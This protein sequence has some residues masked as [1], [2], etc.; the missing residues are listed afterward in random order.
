MK[1]LGST[2]LWAALAAVMAVGS[3]TFAVDEPIKDA[4]Q[5]SKTAYLGLGVAPMHPALTRQLPDVIG[6]GQGVLVAE[7]TKGSISS[8]TT[9]ETSLSST[10]CSRAMCPIEVIVEAPI[11]RTRSAIGSVMAKI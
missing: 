9:Y 8:G 3:P 4:A 6:K 2:I 10:R 5:S 11:L 7:I 1:R